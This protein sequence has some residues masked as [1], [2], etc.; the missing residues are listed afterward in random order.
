MSRDGGAWAPT[1]SVPP[2]EQQWA[3]VTFKRLTLGLQ[4]AGRSSRGPEFSSEHPYRAA[5][6]S[7]ALAL[8]DQMPLASFPCSGRDLLKQ[9][10]ARHKPDAQ[11]G[12][13][14]PQVG[15]GHFSES[16]VGNPLLS[17]GSG[18]FLPGREGGSEINSTE[19]WVTF[20]SLQSHLQFWSVTSH[21]VL[22][23]CARTWLFLVGV[24]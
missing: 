23:A 1:V 22:T 19:E 20:T 14:V 13:S 24:I 6:N 11:M 7:V 4:S 2:Q 18:E 12:R 9:K 21:T 5:H 16:S 15:M 10:A 17:R 8:G 3:E